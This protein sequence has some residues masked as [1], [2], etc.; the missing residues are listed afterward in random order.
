MPNTYTVVE[1]A[2]LL[3]SDQD[4]IRAGIRNRT[5]PFGVCWEGEK[6]YVYKVLKD[7]LDQALQ[8]GMNNPFMENQLEDMRK[9]LAEMNKR[10]D[11]LVMLMAKRAV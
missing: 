7:P 1:A 11:D 8:N 10:I 9:N 2:K 5:F 6:R 4:S 3:D